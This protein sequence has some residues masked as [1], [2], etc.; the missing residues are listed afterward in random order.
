MIL[1]SRSGILAG[2]ATLMAL[3]AAPA[4]AGP[5]V[6]I[7]VDSGKVLHQQDASTPWFPAS[8]TKLMTAYVALKEVA[9]GRITMDTPLI[10]SPRASAASP[11][12]MGFPPGTEVTLENALRMIMVKSANDVSVTIAEGI[13]GSVET[14]SAMMNREAGRLGMANSNFVNPNGWPDPDNRTSARDMAI[15]GR[16]LLLE[17]PEHGDLWGI[18]AIKFGKRIMRNT[19][20][21]VGRYPGTLG[22]KTGFICSSGF[23]VVAAAERN[24]RR[25]IAVVMGAHTAAERTIRTAELLDK[26]FA[27]MGW[28]GTTIDA[29]PAGFGPPPD[30]RPDVCG[31]RR[32]IP[33]EDDGETP[34]AA[35]VGNQ[36]DN[37]ILSAFQPA[38]TPGVAAVRG[39]G[40]RWSLA[41]RVN[42]EPIAVWTGRKSGSTALARGPVGVDAPVAGVV[43]AGAQAFAP[44]GA[45][46]GG[47]TLR[48]GPLMLQGSVP[49]AP[50]AGI[51][52]G[53]K[54]APAGNRGAIAAR[55]APDGARPAARKP[56]P[57]K[58]VAAKPVAAKPVDAKPADLKPLATRPAP[59]KPT[60][61]KPLAGKPAE[62]RPAG[63]KPVAGKPVSGKP[64]PTR[65]K[66]QPGAEDPVRKPKPQA[67]VGAPMRILPTALPAE[68][69]APR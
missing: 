69:P 58:P 57:A 34:V 14:F 30:L 2:L 7:D 26:G 59:L 28:G 24:G 9:A 18:G 4:L 50:G 33:S 39:T 62:T 66:P 47:G 51:G 27:S 60:A 13:A 3:A 45:P 61:G 41:P 11:S 42:S 19:N 36:G 35:G 52:F 65:A 63:A 68:R 10:V 5:S 48:E 16:A 49:G 20:G 15:L 37:P 40:G 22:M 1:Q 23:N 32:G 54:P 31:K 55:P 25:L 64:A 43:P 44:D 21:L 46:A 56:A 8:V 67:G 53:A 6:V 12:K 38:M 17:F 29:L